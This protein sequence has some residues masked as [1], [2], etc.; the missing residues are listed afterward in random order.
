MTPSYKMINSD[1]SEIKLQHSSALIQLRLLDTVEIK[2]KFP[3]MELMQLAPAIWP[4]ALNQVQDM[5]PVS[6]LHLNQKLLRQ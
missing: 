3:L 4:I 6:T 1:H 5:I 2:S